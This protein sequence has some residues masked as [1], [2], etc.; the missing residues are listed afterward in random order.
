VSPPAGSDACE[1]A[2][3]ISTFRGAELEDFVRHF[4]AV[5]DVELDDVVARRGAF[6]ERMAFT[7][8]GTRDDLRAFWTDVR[9][10]IGSLNRT[11]D[12]GDGIP[13]DDYRGR[14]GWP[15]IRATLLPALPGAPAWMLELRSALVGAGFGPGDD[16]EAGAD[17]RL[18]VLASDAVEVLFA[19]AGG[20]WRVEVSLPDWDDWYPAESVLAAIGATPAADALLDALDALAAADPGGLL[21]RVR[22]AR[23]QTSDA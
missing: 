10:W 1:L 14:G 4:A 18:A 22:G 12:W 16:E 19:R 9:S 15:E 13:F 2:E 8:R 20:T 21:A 17:E 6:R 3:Q 7:A 5:R 11:A 23:E